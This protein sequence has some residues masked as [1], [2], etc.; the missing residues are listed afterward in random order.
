[1]LKVIGAGLSRTGTLSLNMALEQLGFRSLH[2]D[3]SRLS[4]VLDGSNEHPD[5]R[6]YDDVDAVTDLPTAFFWRELMEAY[7]DSKVIL[8]L[9]NVDDWWVSIQEHFRF[10]YV[11]EESRIKHKLGKRFGIAAWQE[12]EYRVIR[13]FL[14]NNV[15]GS[16]RPTEFLYKKRYIEHNEHVMA[17][18]PR[19]RLLVMDIAAGDGWAPLCAFLDKPVPD[20][21]FPHG[22][23]SGAG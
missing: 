23:K 13:R 4:D 12:G 16:P 8:T 19:E 3:L 20:C 2:F 22:H 14:R 15:Y 6:R 18:V 1:M 17:C 11:P 21:P 10:H 7:P 5:F 9:R